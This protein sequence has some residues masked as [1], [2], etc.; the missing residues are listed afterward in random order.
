MLDKL[1]KTGEALSNLVADEDS[2]KIH[3]ILENDNARY[4][5]LR[6]ELRERQQALER[7]LQESR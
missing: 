5:A 7:A 6:T 4:A 1:N 3:E 2:A